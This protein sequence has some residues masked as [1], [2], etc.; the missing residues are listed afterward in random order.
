MRI[1]VIKNNIAAVAF[2]GLGIIWG[3]NFLYMRLATQYISPL[4]IVFLRVIISVLPLLVL[5]IVTRAFKKW[6]LKHWHHFLF[7]SVLATVIYYFCFVKGAQILYSGIAGAM[8]GATPIFSFILGTIFIKEE[9]L[10]A[11]KVLGLIIGTIGIILLANPAGLSSSEDFFKGFLYMII[12]SLSFGASFIYA[13][14]YLTP[15]NIS[16][17]ASTSYQ[18]VM[19]TLILL[20]TT[21]LNDIGNILVNTEAFIGLVIGLSLLGTGIAYL[22]YYYLINSMGAVKASSVTYIPPVVA[23]AVGI[24]IGNEPISILD[25]MGAFIVLSGVYLLK[26]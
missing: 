15:L 13:K 1:S 2:I 24:I 16:A 10:T 26:K 8:S 22:I 19:A 11:S 9:K 20:V 5:G 14:K 4:Q 3:T 23:L 21:D 17:T 7:M 18:L 25:C 12:G 6:H